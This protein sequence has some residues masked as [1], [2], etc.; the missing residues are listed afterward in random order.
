VFGLDHPGRAFIARAVLARYGGD[1]RWA[2]KR[3]V[4]LGLDP[5]WLPAASALG[6]ALRLG[7]TISVGQRGVLRASELRPGKDQL[8][9]I[10]PP[11]GSLARGEAVST[12]LAALAGILNLAPNLVVPGSAVEEE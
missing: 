8:T 12:R 10:A 7:F 5:E 2:D 9:L 4:A 11:W 1:E 6:A 3:A